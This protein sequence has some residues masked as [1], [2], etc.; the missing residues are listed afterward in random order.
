M[1]K[2]YAPENRRDKS[3]MVQVT[4]AEKEKIEDAATRMGMTISSYC[5]FV[6]ITKED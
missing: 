3:I 2:A 5:R 4:Q 1:K 6:L